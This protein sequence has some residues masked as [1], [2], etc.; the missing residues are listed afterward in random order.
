VDLKPAENKK[1]FMRHNVPSTQANAVQKT[2][3][4]ATAI[5]QPN[6]E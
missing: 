3:L 2:N 1:G 4:K 6:V 5:P